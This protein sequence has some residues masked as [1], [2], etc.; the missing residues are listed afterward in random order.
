MKQL[1]AAGAFGK[2]FPTRKEMEKA[3]DFERGVVIDIVNQSVRGTAGK[4]IHFIGLK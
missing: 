2:G 4:R 1:L 3:M